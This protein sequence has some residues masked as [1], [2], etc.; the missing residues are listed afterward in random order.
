[1]RRLFLALALSCLPVIAAA[2]P[3]AYTINRNETEVGFS[4]RLAATRGRGVMPIESADLRLDF[5]K[6]SRSKVSVVM[7]AAGATTSL[8]FVTTAM[9]GETVLDTGRFPQIRFASTSVSGGRTG[10]VVRGNLTIRGVTRQVDLSAR[11]FRKPDR[12]PGDLSRL[13][14]LLEGEVSRA[15]FGAAGFP[16]L[17]GD[18]INL[19]ILATI[20]RAL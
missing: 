13:T 19:R 15:A 17:V 9:K 1:M 8:P 12:D 11:F 2:A 3:V 20:D 14:I 6:V 7:N 18:M 16:D 10:V 4:Y 5:K